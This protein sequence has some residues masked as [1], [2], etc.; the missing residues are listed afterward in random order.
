MDILQCNTLTSEQEQHIEELYALCCLQEPLSLE[1]FLVSDMNVEPE[2]PCFFLGYEA[3][4]LVSV[5]TAFFPTKE[6]VEFTGFTHPG[7]RERGYMTALIAA[8]LPLFSHTTYTQALFIR[9]KGSQSGEKYLSKRYPTIARTEYV[10]E[11]KS[12]E[13]K[14]RQS[15]GML[16]EVT[17]QTTPNLPSL[18]P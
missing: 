7:K 16:T 13:W 1:L 6:E 15:T 18:P 3:A 17:Q 2:K 11:L 12:S 14:T 9:E 5:L 8:A 10:L 4:Q